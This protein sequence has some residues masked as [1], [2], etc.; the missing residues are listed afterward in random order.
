M[1]DVS[2]RY[3]N[4]EIR[5]EWLRNDPARRPAGRALE[6]MPRGP[7]AEPLHPPGLTHPQPVTSGAVNLLPQYRHEPSDI[8]NQTAKLELDLAPRLRP[9]TIAARKIFSA[10]MRAC[11]RILGAHAVIATKAPHT[12]RQTSSSKRTSS[13]GPDLAPIL[14]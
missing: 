13:A 4:P 1:W 10:P 5:D 2:H 14:E 12:H 8:G 6:A 9:H 7:P 3:F 11:P